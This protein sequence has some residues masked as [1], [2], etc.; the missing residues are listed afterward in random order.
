[1]RTSALLA[2]TALLMLV[3]AAAARAEY[4]AY[5]LEVV[6]TYD[7]QINKRERC[8]RSS[9]RTGLAPEVYQRTHGGE[10]RIGVML[11]ATWMCYG[12]TSNYEP[13]CPRP[14]PRKG[15]FAAGDSVRI[16]LNKHVTKGWTG[17]IEVAYYQGSVN[18]NVYGVR[19]ADRQNVYARYYEKDLEKSSGSPAQ[20]S[21]GGPATQPVAAT[22]QTGAQAPG[23]QTTATRTAPPKPAQTPAAAPRSQPGTAPP[24]ASAPKPGAAP[25]AQAA[26][27]QSEPPQ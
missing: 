3:S 18:S 5:E 17:T 23:V 25:A 14:A 13:V 16:K 26:P 11:L 12:D 8:R 9:I 7:C 21:Q 24:S 22:V 6:D 19:F 20:A 15:K 10:Q 4:R 2:A 1:L 27:T